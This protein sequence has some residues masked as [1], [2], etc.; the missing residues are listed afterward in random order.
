M[1]PATTNLPSQAGQSGLY[2]TLAGDIVPIQTKKRPG[3]VFILKVVKLH[4]LAKMP[5]RA[6]EGSIGYD[7]YL[8]E[9]VILQPGDRVKLDIGLAMRPPHGHYIRLA[10]KS[11][12]AAVGLDVKAGVIDSDYTGPIKVLLHH[13]GNQKLT[14]HQGQPIAQMILERA[15]TAYMEEVQQL[16]STRR[17]HM[18]FGMMPQRV[19]AGA[20]ALTSTPTVVSAFEPLALIGPSGATGVRSPSPPT[21]T[22]KKT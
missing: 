12:L 13:H 6:T 16:P 15:S 5:S 19:G 20:V 7:L 2:P 1:D 21:T 22:F 4:P 10:S 17:L 18:G 9:D 8:I 11:K 14:M 3:D